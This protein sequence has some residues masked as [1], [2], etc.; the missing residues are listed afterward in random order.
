MRSD[1]PLSLV[2]KGKRALPK[3]YLPNVITTLG[4]SPEEG[5]FLETLIDLSR[6]REARER[7]FYVS[8]LARL[9][10]ARSR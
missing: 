4:L 1:S 5:R 2:L 3:K 10:P 7:A 6:A 8:R 9:R